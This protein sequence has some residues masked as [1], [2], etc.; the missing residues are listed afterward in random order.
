MAELV[1][2]HNEVVVRLGPMEALAAC[3]RQLRVPF[4]DLRMVQVREDP[5]E[6]LAWFR[7]PGF[8]WP[9]VCA[10]GTARRGG[11][12]EFAAAHAGQSAVVLDVE[13]GR[14]DRLVVTCPDAVGIAAELAVLLLE[15]GPGGAP[16]GH[17]KGRRLSGRGQLGNGTLQRRAS[18]QGPAL[19]KRQGLRGALSGPGPSPSPSH[20]GRSGRA[21]SR[22]ARPFGPAYERIAIATGMLDRVKS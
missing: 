8:F 3:R 1:L 10:V 22:Q 15:R 17:G 5:L 9:G 7:L 18:E 21:L 16:G 11:R 19:E 20:L 6:G 4:S 2:R 13:G 14:W 12:R